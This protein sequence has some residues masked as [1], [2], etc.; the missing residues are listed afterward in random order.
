MHCTKTALIAVCL[1]LHWPAMQNTIFDFCLKY[2]F[3]R[4][5]HSIYSCYRHAHFGG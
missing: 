5:C 1:T 4:G 3:S 2:M